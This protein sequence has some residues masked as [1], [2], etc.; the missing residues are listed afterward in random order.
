MR[1]EQGSLCVPVL[2]A[3]ETETEAKNRDENVIFVPVPTADEA[4]AKNRD[5][6]VIFVPVSTAGEVETKNRDMNVTFVPVPTRA[7]LRPSIETRM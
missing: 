6:N 1:W 3:G 4:E 2:I 5:K 7:R